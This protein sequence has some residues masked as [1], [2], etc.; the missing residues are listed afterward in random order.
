M[1]VLIGKSGCGKTSIAKSLEKYIKRIITYT[2]RPRR[3]D[4]N[5]D[6]DYHFVSEK[7]FE[8]LIKANNFLEYQSY[9]NWYYGTSYSGLDNNSVIILSP[10][11]LERLQEN[12]NLDI[13][14]FYIKVDQESRLNN[15]YNTREDNEEI[16]RR[17]KT[18]EI[19]FRD[20]ENKVDHVICNIGYQY[21]PDLLANKI[22]KIYSKG[23]VN[24]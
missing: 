5:E 2:S 16:N 22:Y 9:N 3:T 15:L 12:N 6:D 19:D 18:D 1:I 17:D 7:E 8:N 11:G 13:T 21:S 23:F 4:E 20:I 10:S 14:S 24:A